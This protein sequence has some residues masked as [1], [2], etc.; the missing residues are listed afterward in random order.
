MIDGKEGYP[1]NL[2]PD[3]I[4]SII[5]EQIENYTNHLDI[6]DFGT[7]MQVGDGIAR[8]YGLGKCMSGE[9]LEFSGGTYG[10]AMNL[11]EDNVGAVILGSDRDIKHRCR[12]SRRR[13][14]D[15]KS[16]GRS[17]PPYRR[18]RRY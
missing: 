6:S 18:Q 17:G 4:S 7:V 11:E 8:V 3:E 15:R 13:S 10:M 14:D 9:L 16:S 5:K 12:R 2:R 1:V